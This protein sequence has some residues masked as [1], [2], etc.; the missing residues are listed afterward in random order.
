MA[1]DRRQ[2]AEGRGQK[3]EDRGQRSDDTQKLGIGNEEY[4][5]AVARDSSSV[6]CVNGVPNIFFR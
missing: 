4:D 1:E 2:R 6:N 3:A 5:G